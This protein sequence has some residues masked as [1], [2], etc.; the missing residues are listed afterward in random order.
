MSFGSYSLP[1]YWLIMYFRRNSTL[2]ICKVVVIGI[3]MYQV[4]LCLIF[5]CDP[6]IL[7]SCFT[8]IFGQSHVVKLASGQRYV[9]ILALLIS[10]PCICSC[11]GLWLVICSYPSFVLLQWPVICRRHYL[12]EN[13]S[14]PPLNVPQLSCFSVTT[15]TFLSIL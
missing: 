10:Q 5:Y 1:F 4:L 14:C 12:S 9:V 6:F 3:L 13:L 11:V 7:I 2:F 15:K 8:V